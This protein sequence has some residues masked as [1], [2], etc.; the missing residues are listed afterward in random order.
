MG[1]TSSASSTSASSTMSN[2]NRMAGLASG[3]DTE[4]LVKAMAAN[5]LKRYNRKAS[6]LQ[7]LQWKQEAYRNQITTLKSFSDKYLTATSKTSLMLSSS[8]SKKLATSSNNLVGV[9]ATGSAKEATYTITSSTAATKSS[10][11]SASNIMNSNVKLD[12]SKFDVAD[13]LSAA[14]TALDKAQGKYNTAAYDFG[15]KSLDYADFMI[16]FAK[17]GSFTDA[18]ASKYGGTSWEEA[19]NGLKAQLDEADPTADNTELYKKISEFAGDIQKNVSDAD[20][21]ESANTAPVDALIKSESALKTAKTNLEDATKAQ[22]TAETNNTKGLTTDIK[23]TLDGK[24]KTISLSG[25]KSSE[26]AKSQFISDL[27]SAFGLT[28]EGKNTFALDENGNLSYKNNE[29]D[30][31]HHTFS[32]GYNTTVGLANTVYGDVSANDSIGSISFGTPLEFVTGED[33]KKTCSLNVNGKDFSFTADTSVTTMMNT[34]NNANLGVKMTFSSFN[35][36]FKLE[37][38]ETGA[39]NEINVSGSL[40]DSLFGTGATRVEGQNSKITISADGGEEATYTSSSNIFTFDGTS[41]DVSKLGTFEAGVNG[42][43]AVTVSTTKDISGTKEFIVN[44]I[45]DYNTLIEGIRKEMTTSR[46]KSNGSFYDPLTED[47]RNEMTT[48]EIDKWESQA[49]VGLLY[50]DSYLNNVLMD[51][52]NTMSKAYGGMTLADMGIKSKD[53]T[54][55]G[56]LSIDEDKL[57]KFL[58]ENSEKATDFFTN[59][60]EGLGRRLSTTIDKA[61]S[62]TSGKVGYLSGFAGVAN[63]GTD[64]K[65]ALYNE[66]SSLQ[67]VVSDLKTRYEKEMER[68]WSRFTTLETYISKMN[69]QS[70]IF[71]SDY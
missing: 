39:N 30:G 17:E 32:V 56:K 41:I 59:I 65:N 28:G 23:V 67:K 3:L 47:Q 52:Q 16:D 11:T 18:F 57:D 15:S 13:K 8:L 4:S 29:E 10:L 27:N 70:S 36:S 46:P 38:T 40:A 60:N 34:I 24:T 35:Q 14:N 50:Q 64:K 1:T 25:V 31:I 37:S 62:T 61:I 5:S 53:W 43:E 20:I 22:K 48:E 9:S 69:S 49:K 21:K 2:L 66:I 33:G 54:D 7:T 26:D 71:N 63:T 45:N 42:A 51:L 6:K 58:M 19:Y 55:Y 12:F 44:F 68:Y